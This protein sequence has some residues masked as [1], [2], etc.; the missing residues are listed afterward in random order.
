MGKLSK[1]EVIHLAKL[2]NLS[3]TSEEVE[4]FSR[5]ISETL[6]YVEKLKELKTENVE[7]TFQ[8]TGLTNVMREDVIKPSLT[9]AE[10][11]RNAKSSY[12]GFFKIKAIF[13]QWI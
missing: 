2:A 12:K 5:Q 11:L 10:A 8:T 3:L 6:D 9:Q 13:S 4:V 7:P 1:D